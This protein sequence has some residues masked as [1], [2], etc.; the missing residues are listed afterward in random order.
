LFFYFFVTSQG[1]GSQ[2]PTLVINHIVLN[3]IINVSQSSSSQLISIICSYSV[4]QSCPKIDWWKQ[5]T[6]GLASTWLVVI[7]WCFWRLYPALVSLLRCL[8]SSSAR[9]TS[10]SFQTHTS[11]NIR[12]SVVFYLSLS[13]CSARAL[14]IAILLQRLLWFRPLGQKFSLHRILS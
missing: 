5:V 9:E 1:L 2:R 13:S 3:K 6:G 8:T 11:V 4:K 14:R 10:P 12:I 7:M